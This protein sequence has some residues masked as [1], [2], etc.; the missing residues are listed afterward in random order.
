MRMEVSGV[1]LLAFST[2]VLP[3]TMASGTI[4]PKGIM[5]GKFS[6]TMPTQT[7]SGIR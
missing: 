1:R 2:T 6:G 7:P 4:Q 5:A 3:Q